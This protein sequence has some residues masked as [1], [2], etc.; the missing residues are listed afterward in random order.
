MELS[1]E[2]LK[3]MM[4]IFRVESEEHLNNLTNLLLQLEKDSKNTHLLEEIFRTAHSMKG[5]SRMMGFTSIEKISHELENIFGLLR[6]GTS[7]LDADD[8]D[9]IYDGI[10]V[11]SKI[12]DKM[13]KDGSEQGIDIN[14]ALEKL[15]KLYSEK[16]AGAATT[17][18]EP[19]KKKAPATTKSRKKK[20]TVETKEKEPSRKAT[21]REP[22]K[23]T[24][25]TA[26]SEQITEAEDF[27]DSVVRVPTRRLDDLMNQVSELFTSK[28]RSNQL[29]NDT[30]KLI[31]DMDALHQDFDRKKSLLGKLTQK[32]MALSEERGVNGMDADWYYEITSLNQ[33]L[34]LNS[35]RTTELKNAL[36]SI[37]EKHSEDNLRNETIIDDIEK[38]LSTIRM[39]PLS[40]IFDHFPRMVRDISKSQK[41]KVNLTIK[42]GSRRVDKKIIQEMKDPLIHILRNCIDHGLEPREE[43][44]KAGK[45]EEGS[46]ILDAEYSGNMVIIRIIDDGRGINTQK[47]AEKAVKKGYIEEGYVKKVSDK[48]LINLI[49]HS[50][51]STAEIIT[52]LSGRGVGLDVVKANI[53]KIKG[54]IF[55]TTRMNIGTSFEIKIPLTLV[56]SHVLIFQVENIKYSIPFSAIERAVRFSEDEIKK[57]G[58]RDMILVNDNPIPLFRLASV[59]ENPTQKLI[60]AGL[61]EKAKTRIDLTADSDEVPF[62]NAIILNVTGNQAA[63]IVDKLVDEQEVV[64]KN[65][66]KQ[67][68]R[69]RNV[70]GVTMLG[71][72]KLCII[73]NPHDLIKSVQLDASKFLLKRKSRT[74]QE[75]PRVLVVDDSITTRTLEKN[76]LESAGY[77]VT[78]ATDGL[79]AYDKL[80]SARFDLIVSDVQMPNLNGFEF[81]EKVRGTPAFSEIPFILVTSLESEEDKKKGIEVGANAYI[82]KGAFDQKNLLETIEKL[83]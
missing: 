29:L 19:P 67:L 31:D 40:T 2:E 82:V 24:A 22:E 41:K 23:E 5:A 14:S 39:L 68:S 8:F 44:R 18:K 1:H 43:R 66:G 59:L 46:I 27:D 65:L 73:L 49:F 9:L 79:Q 81:A 83:I 17:A 53:E 61:M 71:D 45:P 50:G 58:K 13:S 6:K 25:I 34:N 28:I 3:E 57:T 12:V 62:H 56:T 30:G 33:I 35:V 78:I 75:K 15:S 54:S 55:V 21:A 32:L 36:G 11:I 10:D 52:D 20:T 70:A 74:D 48:E 37:Y 4:S 60:D 26:T 16:E 69:V 51:F 42:G 72:G 76:I 80:M 64:V 38:S 47:I 77:D 7:D 63:F